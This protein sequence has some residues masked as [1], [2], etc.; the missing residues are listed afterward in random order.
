MKPDQQQ[1]LL[2]KIRLDW[3][4]YSSKIEGNSLTFGETKVLLLWGNTAQ[5]KPLRDHLEI[6]GHNEAV[7][8]IFEIFKGND[9]DLTEHFIREFHKVIIPEEYYLDAR[10]AEGL[11]TKR[12]IIPGKYKTEPNHVETITGEMFF[13]ATPEETPAKMND[14][15][16][17]YHKEVKT[18]KN[19]PLIIASLFHYNFVRIHPFDYGNG[20]LSRLIMNIIL[21]KYGYPPVIIETAMKNDYLNSLQYADA[22]DFDKFI[23]FIGERLIESLELWLKA[24]KGEPIEDID[25]IEKTV[26]MLEKKIKK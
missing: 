1:R 5:G 23:V 18:G 9:I 8:Y 3:N 2:Q 25:D 14:L 4:Y 13:F 15:M 22:E 7:E 17:W 6:R 24:A 12:K 21:M 11:P 16:K 19:H 26:K 20:R 10:S